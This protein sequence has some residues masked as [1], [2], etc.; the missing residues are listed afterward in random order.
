M[1]QIVLG[2]A[3]HVD[4][5]KTLLIKALTGV[6]TDRL[7]EEKRR[8]ITIEL[9]FAYLS[10][11]SGSRV[12]IIDVPGHEKFVKNMVAGAGGIDCILLVIAAD[13]GVMPQT[14]EHVDICSLLGIQRGLVALNKIDLVDDE[15][16]ALADDEIRDF[17]K[18][19]FLA[20]SP[21]VPVSSVT[22]EGLP[23]LITELEKLVKDTPGRDSSGLFRLP[24]DRIFTMK[25]FGTVVTGTLLSGQV[26]KG[27]MVEILPGKNKAKVRGIQVH[28]QEVAC[29]LAGQ[30]TAI[31]LQAV[32]K[33]LI[34]RGDLLTHPGNYEPT[35]KILTYLQLLPGTARPLRSRT[36][37]SFHLGTAR[38][39]GRIVL[40]S[41]DEIPPGE[42]GFAVIYLERP[43]AA[44]FRDRFI[45]RSFAYTQT[46]GGGEVLDPHPQKIRP[47][48]AETLKELEILR[49][50][51][52]VEIIELWIDR[53]GYEGLTQER[54]P[55]KTNLPPQ[56]IP[57][58][59]QRLISQGRIIQLDSLL[60]HQ[61]RYEEAQRRIRECLQDYHH[62]F[63]LRSGIS[64]EE[65]RGKLDL[66]LKERMFSHLLQKLIDTQKISLKKESISLVEH[67]VE[68]PQEKKE[69]KDKIEKLYQEGGLEPPTLKD[70]EGSLAAQK[71]EIREA[72]SLLS[73]EGLL[74]R[75][76]DELY[77][78]AKPCQRLEQRLR[79]FLSRK[80]EIST[81]EFKDLTR[82]SRKY[83][84]PLLEYFDARKIT[85]RVGDKR[86]LR[87]RIA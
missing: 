85:I 22:G 25:G 35:S 2:T 55:G 18:G 14:R 82:V 74:I 36:R 73:R 51:G 65:L 8:G 20:G 49:S 6:D 78:H 4:H 15:I 64:R 34:Q 70:L 67:R 38:V 3:G 48:S 72:V 81:Q 1:K 39:L 75:V 83:T 84:I 9:G 21:I 47:H 66:K 28:N 5:G 45:L 59:I 13:E 24:I 40:L 80:K 50:G 87:E 60:I 23:E 71:K 42:E 7:K 17:L 76:K 44:S 31:N 41:R 61:R 77:F 16:R 86:K 33:S 68:L 52:A 63:P 56:D 19:S 43:I 79:D 12:G 27:E 69:L 11:P 58:L 54:L 46:I 10:L 30:R 29:A 57:E 37:L 26:S 32:E 53:T 62:K